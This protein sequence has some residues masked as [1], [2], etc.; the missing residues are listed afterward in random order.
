MNIL[1]KN[2]QENF[3][4]YLARMNASCRT[5]TKSM[6]PFY[7]IGYNKILDVGCADGS[8]M[9]SIRGIN[10]AV[11]IVG[12]DLNSQFVELAKNK[13]FEVYCKSLEEVTDMYDCII[14]SSVL[15][16]ISSYAP[17][18]LERFTGNPIQKALHIAYNHLNDGGRL[19]IRDG[20]MDNCNNSICY[21]HFTNPEDK[22]WLYKFCKENKYPYYRA[23]WFVEVDKYN[24]KCLT[25][26]AQEFMAT[27]TW[28]E[29]SWNREIQEKF[30]ILPEKEWQ[31]IIEEEGFFIESFTKSKE[32]Y[33]KYLTPKVLMFDM[34]NQNTIF[35]YM[36]C[37]IIAKK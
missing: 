36:T 21:L 32:E 31:N 13:H 27:W 25:T 33:P 5:S 10:P 30:C 2:S 9:E 19:I 15:H 14:F 1:E 17:N 8:L 6:I 4:T 3:A 29:K 37:S 35:P 12:I 16:E 28:G 20:L 23:G 26:L 22:Q 11:N 7:T 18:E 24:V 34:E